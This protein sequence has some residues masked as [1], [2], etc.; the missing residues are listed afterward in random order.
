M[1]GVASDNYFKPGNSLPDLTLVGLALTIEL[2]ALGPMTILPL[3]RLYIERQ[4]QPEMLNFVDTEDVVALFDI[5]FD[6]IA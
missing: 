5:F 6:H 1:I 4:V 3:R 2:D